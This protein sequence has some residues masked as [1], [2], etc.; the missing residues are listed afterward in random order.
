[1]NEHSAPSLSLHAAPDAAITTMIVVTAVWVAVAVVW[2]AP[3]SQMK[4]ITRTSSLPMATLPEQPVVQLAFARHQDD[5]NTVLLAGED[6]H[7]QAV[8]HIAAGNLLDTM[9][10]V[11]GY[12]LL[13]IALSLL[14]A[15]ASGP[16]AMTVFGAGLLL[17]TALAIADL[18]ENYGIATALSAVQHGQVMTDAARRIMVA[19]AFVKWTLMALIGIGLGVAAALH[20]RTWGRRYVAPVLLAVSMVML[21]RV[22]RHGVTLLPVMQAAPAQPTDLRLIPAAVRQ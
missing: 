6:G 17:A 11:P 8:A 2:I 13:L 10:L 3:H 7:Q 14:I 20:H 18:T 16:A 22:A 4:G 21:A 1:M 19:A 9:V 12:T 5:I 15:R